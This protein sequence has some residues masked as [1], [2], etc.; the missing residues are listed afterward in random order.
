MRLH[1]L[2]LTAIGPFRDQVELDFSR[3][4]SSG[5][6]LLEGP[7]GSGKTTIIDAISFALYGRVAQV[8]ATGERL[9]SHHADPRTEPVV[10]LVFETQNG[11]FRIRRTPTHDRP[12]RGGAG[13]TKV[14]GSI[15][16]WRVTSP[17]DLDAGEPIS[18][19]VAEADDEILRAVGL[20]HA[21]FVQ[22]MVLPQGEFANF[23]R[24]K[25]DDK[26]AL[27][28]K[29]FGT[30][31]VAALQQELIDGRRRAELRRAETAA[32]I[33]RA[34]HAFAHIA[35]LEAEAAAALDSAA[36]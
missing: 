34:A 28:Q 8:S 9:R 20:N 22:T 19:R 10:E 31:L 25:T 14:Q 21:Q 2:R 13:T 32:E 26:R 1:R 12:K 5:L 29:L 16:L 3:L 7:T 11:I 30:E 18:T 6:F 17:D 35:R 4:G 27:L 15:K 24:S 36:T 23:L 33:G